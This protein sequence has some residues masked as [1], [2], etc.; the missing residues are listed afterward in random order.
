MDEMN[1]INPDIKEVMVGVRNLRKLQI[2]P[3]S[4]IDQFK[5]TDLFTEVLG[6]LISKDIKQDVALIVFFTNILR[7]NLPKILELVIDESEDVKNLIGEITNNQLTDI[8]KTIYEVNYSYISKNV[9]GLLKNI[10]KE[11]LSARPLQPSAVSMDTDLKTSS[12]SPGE[13]E[14]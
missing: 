10:P 4:V 5:L 11:S 9:S 14:D 8:A 13:M 3:L 12:E 7:S 1:T 2:F 6:S